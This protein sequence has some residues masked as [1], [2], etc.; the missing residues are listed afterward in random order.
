MRGDQKTSSPFNRPSNSALYKPVAFS[1]L[2]TT[3]PEDA[4]VVANKAYARET[5]AHRTNGQ[6]ENDANDDAR[7]TTH[8]H[9]HHHHTPDAIARVTPPLAAPRARSIGPI[10]ATT[11][12]SARARANERRAHRRRPRSPRARDHRSP[13]ERDITDVRT[14]T[15]ARARALEITA[16]RSIVAST[17]VASRLFPSSLGRTMGR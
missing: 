1:K 16:L 4:R 15:R 7:N 6:Y 10:D 12:L 17:C 3:P 14:S 5:H 9:T 8:H 13:T 2:V 11:S